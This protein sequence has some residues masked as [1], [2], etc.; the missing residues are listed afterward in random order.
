MLVAALG[1]WLC[2]CLLFSLVRVFNWIFCCSQGKILLSVFI[3]FMIHTLKGKE[4]Q[5]ACSL[6]FWWWGQLWE[7]RLNIKWVLSWCNRWLSFK[8]RQGTVSILVRLREMWNSV[9]HSFVPT[10][11]YL[12]DVWFIFRS[13][14]I[15]QLRSSLPRPVP[16][17]R[18]ASES[19]CSVILL[20]FSGFSFDV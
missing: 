10:L 4:A 16:M 9:V 15:E 8:Q 19:N 2:G 17:M 1:Y 14:L 6:W 12:C 11:D 5:K 20:A 7:P 13:Y 3:H 18:W